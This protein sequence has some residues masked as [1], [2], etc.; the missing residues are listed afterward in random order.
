MN[1]QPP[2]KRQSDKHRQHP[3]R[4]NSSAPAHMPFFLYRYKLSLSKSSADEYWSV[5]S[6][7]PEA[8]AETEPDSAKLYETLVSYPMPTHS[9]HILIALV[10]TRLTSLRQIPT[11]SMAMPRVRVSSWA[12]V[13]V[14]HFIDFS[15]SYAIFV[16]SLSNGRYR[17]FPVAPVRVLRRGQK[18]VIVLLAFW[19]NE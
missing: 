11:P 5:A 10:K 13:F 17:I 1:R 9:K 18:Q 16:L 15:L 12:F 6:P 8:K 3:D 4:S 2:E 19:T 7:R 14:F